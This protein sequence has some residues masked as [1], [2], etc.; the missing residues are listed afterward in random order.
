MQITYDIYDE[1]SKAD[2]YCTKSL[3]YYSGDR[4]IYELPLK[5]I[6]RSTMSE[7]SGNV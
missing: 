2:F 6:L 4:F 7:K 3:D 5:N 1:K